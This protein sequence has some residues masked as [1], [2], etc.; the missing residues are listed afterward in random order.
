[1]PTVADL[2]KELRELGIGLHEIQIP[3]RWY[4]EIIRHAEELAETREET[5]EEDVY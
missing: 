3:Y 5:E 4:R 2:V 1:M